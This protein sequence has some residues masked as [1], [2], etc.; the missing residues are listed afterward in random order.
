MLELGMCILQSDE[1]SETFDK[2]L[3]KLIVER[4]IYISATHSVGGCC[5]SHQSKVPN[6]SAVDKQRHVEQTGRCWPNT[7]LYTGITGQD[8][9]DPNLLSDI[10]DA[11]HRWLNLYVPEVVQTQKNESELGITLTEQM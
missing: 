9:M 1:M 10:G 3:W 11:H 2:K 6:L 8:G 5:C 4:S 7:L